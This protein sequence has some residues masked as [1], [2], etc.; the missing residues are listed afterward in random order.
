MKQ[1]RTLASARVPTSRP[2]GESAAEGDV[3]FTE[4]GATGVDDECGAGE[5]CVTVTATETTGDDLRLL[6][7]EATSDSW[8]HDYRSVPTPS[9]VVSEYPP[10]PD[11]FPARIRIPFEENLFA[12]GRVMRAV[13]RYDSWWKSLSG[14]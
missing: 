4:A 13:M 10:V 7:Y 6:L 12:T 14:K 8:P 1:R 2:A 5:L 9:W 11:E 3:E